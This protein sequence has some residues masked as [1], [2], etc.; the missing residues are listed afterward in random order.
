MHSQHFDRIRPA[1][2]VFA[3]LAAAVLLV[4]CST[5][6]DGADD[7]AGSS[8]SSQSG[9]ESFGLSPV[10]SVTAL[11]PDDIAGKTLDV[12]IYTDGAPL[13][14]LED[15]KVVGIN[16]DLAE[17]V[18][19]VSG[20]DFNVIG[21]GS[22]DSIIPGVQTGRYDTAFAGFGITEERQAIF[23]LVYN[24]ALPTGFASK[25][26]GGLEISEKSD[27]CGAQ[28]GTL[29]GSFFIDQVQKI[30]D[31]CASDGDPEITI[32]SFPAQTDAVLAVSTGR[33]DVYAVSSEQLAF[34][35]AEEG[36]GLAV[37]PFVFDPIPHG[38]GVAKDSPLG[39]VFVE[40]FKALIEDGTY[41]EIL[42][43]W[44]ISSAAITADQ[45]VINPL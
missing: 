43:K 8:G 15:G 11:V 32:Q 14:F 19:E 5:S 26:D 1:A 36:S 45:I 28:V 2:A 4:G 27:L 20:L 3:G 35:A 42:D 6:T 40:S 30:S 7:S 13:Q 39:P 31:S 9:A 12:A 34:A 17:A 41:A 22:W 23:D 29:A 18:S 25:A 21:V 44:G 38:V 10:D 16:A 37:Q 24:F 33:V